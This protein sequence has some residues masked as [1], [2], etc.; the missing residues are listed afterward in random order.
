MYHLP[1]TTFCV[2]SLPGLLLSG[3]PTGC[4]FQGKVVVFSVDKVDG[5]TALQG[6]TEVL[7]KIYWGKIMITEN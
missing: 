1:G 3:L 4:V 5:E 6:A 2:H 7:C